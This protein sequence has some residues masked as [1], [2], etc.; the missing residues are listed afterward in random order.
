[1]IDV[2]EAI[3]ENSN[4]SVG[5]SSGVLPIGWAD[6]KILRTF[7]STAARKAQFVE[8]LFT[9]TPVQTKLVLGQLGWT[10]EDLLSLHQFGLTETRPGVYLDVVTGPTA[11]LYEAYVGSA[12]SAPKPGVLR[13]GLGAR[14]YGHEVSIRNGEKKP[15]THHRQVLQQGWN[16]NYR[17]LVRFP[18]GTSSNYSLVSESAIMIFL[19]T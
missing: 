8:T 10:C 2:A 17:L 1:M 5:L 9:A 14:R 6:W 19:D 18:L 12:T 16:S 13:A 4:F 3:P 7:G 15:S 11:Y